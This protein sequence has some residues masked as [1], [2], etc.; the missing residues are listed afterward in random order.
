[1]LVDDMIEHNGLEMLVHRL[2]SLVENS[3][4][5]S[6]AVFNT[7]AT[8]ENMIEVRPAIAEQLVQLG[9]Q[10]TGFLRSGKA[11]SV[12]ARL[13]CFLL[14]PS[15]GYALPCAAFFLLQH[16]EVT[17]SQSQQRKTRFRRSRRLRLS[18]SSPDHHRSC[19]WPASSTQMVLQ[20]RA[21]PASYLT[22]SIFFASRP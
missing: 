2:T 9:D 20:T 6:K 7:L 10:K 1:M 3:E 13:P 8:F 14:V 18:H 16:H 21:L 22:D 15:E 4:D 11:I 17:L 12:S 19:Q 5:E